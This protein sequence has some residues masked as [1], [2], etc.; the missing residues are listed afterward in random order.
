MIILL[1]VLAFLLIS[2]SVF[3]HEAYV[4]D[5][6]QFNQGLS[7]YTEYPLS[8]LFDNSNFLI[9]IIIATLVLISY[10]LF[11]LWS[12]TNWATY[13]DKLTKKATIFGHLTLRVGLAISLFISAQ[14][15]SFL[16]PELSLEQMPLGGTIKFLLY[17]LSAIILIGSFTEFA[18]F[19]VLLIFLYAFI[20]FG[21]YMITYANYF[22]V[23][24]VL[25][26]FGSQVFSLDNFLFGK[27][28]MIRK[29]EKFKEFEIPFIRI[30]YG[31]A[32]IYA[33]YTIK[34]L[35]QN[36]TETV[37]NQYNLQNFFQATS[38]FIAAGTGLVEIL[39]G[40]FILCGF[41]MRWTII[42]LLSLMTISIFYFREMV[43]PHYILYSISLLLFINSADKFT[44]DHYLASWIR[45]KV[46]FL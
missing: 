30:L 40:I 43:W 8:P 3:A 23:V 16:G 41:A 46:Q 28:L 1:G 31:I 11:I 27:G 10:I 34:F 18:A 45:K 19:I 20:H 17:A 21:A 9:F 2:K 13:L 29:L 36:L 33:G 12:A 6:T 44:I 7:Q 26:L 5:K 24:T 32:L 38:N 22:G 39:I 14:N 15:N 4:L 25:T 37:Y 35:H 42:I